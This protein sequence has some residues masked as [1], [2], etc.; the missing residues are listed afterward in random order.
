VTE[1]TTRADIEAVTRRWEEALAAHDLDR[2]IATYAPDAELVSPLVRGVQ[3][4]R[5]DAY[6]R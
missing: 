4:L 6:Y 5:Q 3:V 2:L 1:A